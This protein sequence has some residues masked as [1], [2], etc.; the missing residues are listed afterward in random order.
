[1]VDAD[2]AGNDG[3]NALAFRTS[4]GLGFMMYIS[5]VHWTLQL[6]RIRLSPLLV[7]FSLPS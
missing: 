3:N 1:M 5:E 7:P 6:I 4:L 2:V